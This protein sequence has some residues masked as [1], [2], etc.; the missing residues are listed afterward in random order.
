MRL[1][2]KFSL[3]K[4]SISLPQVADIGNLYDGIKYYNRGGSTSDYGGYRH[5]RVPPL[6]LRF[7]TGSDDK[8][9]EIIPVCPKLS[10]FKLTVTPALAD[11]GDVLKTSP[12]TLERLTLIF[13]SSNEN[14]EPDPN[15]SQPQPL[16]GLLPFLQS[17]GNRISCL[18]ITFSGSERVRIRAQDFSTIAENCPLLEI[19]SVSKF[20]VDQL[21]ETVSALPTAKFNFLTQLRLSDFEVETCGREFFLF[22]LANC[23]DI[24]YLSINFHSTT[25]YFNDFLLDD[26]LL[27]NSFGRLEHFFLTEVSLTLI[28]ALRMISSRPKLRSIGHLLQWDVEASE[29]EAFAQILRRAK[30]LNLLQDITIY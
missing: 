19:L 8:L 16:P 5:R 23:L 7:Y 2:D 12:N 20:H 15:S 22:I 3:Y 21:A 24:E 9:S 6:K 26:I 25:F 28:S 11:L 10:N 4:I 17:C 13:G 14:S 18:E 27:L 30:S 29:L 1:V